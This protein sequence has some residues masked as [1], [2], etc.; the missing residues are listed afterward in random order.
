[1]SRIIKT[2]EGLFV[3]NKIRIDLI[4]MVKPVIYRKRK[5]GRLNIKYINFPSRYVGKRFRLRLEPV[6]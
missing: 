5:Y 2:N 4:W 1:M 6:K 3:D